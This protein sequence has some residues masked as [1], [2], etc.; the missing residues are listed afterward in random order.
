MN[1]A[2]TIDPNDTYPLIFQS[3][4]GVPRLINLVCDNALVYGYAE[5]AEE[6]SR[7]IVQKVLQDKAQGFSPIVKRV[8]PVQEAEKMYEATPEHQPVSDIGQRKPALSTIERAAARLR[9]DG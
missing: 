4:N 3:T 8:N 2:A 9:G 7:S 6:I 5:D 1:I